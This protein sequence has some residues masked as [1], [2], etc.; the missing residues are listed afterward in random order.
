MPPRHPPPSP[1][2]SHTPQS[3]PP[4]ASPP[5]TSQATPQATPIAEPRTPPSKASPPHAAFAEI[6]DL[7]SPISTDAA[8][9]RARH[10]SSKTHPPPAPP[11]STPLS[12][13]KAAPDSSSIELE[14]PH[15]D[16]L[17][18]IDE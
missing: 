18:S 9:P 17:S 11:S 16:P 6:K 13:N 14:N 5:A 7:D 3:K 2:E 1:P 10:G 12:P 15:S 8:S 4:R